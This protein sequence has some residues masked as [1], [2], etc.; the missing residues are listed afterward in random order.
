MREAALDEVRRMIREDEPPRPSQRLSTLEAQAR[1]TVSARRGLDERRL[2]RLLRGDLDWVAMKCLEKNRNRRYEGAGA[3][4][5]DVERH[6][7]DEPVEAR[8]PTAWYR[9]RK[10]ARRNRARLLAAAVALFVVLPAV[11]GSVGWALGDRAERRKNAERRVD[12]GLA[13]VEQ[14]YGRGRWPSAREVAGGLEPLL[15]GG[16]SPDRAERLRAWRADLD[17]VDRLAEIRL[18]QA[19]TLG[20]LAWADGEYAL[21]FREYG[22]DVETLDP[23]RA[24]ERIRT[25]L[26]RVELTAAL[27]DWARLRRDGRRSDGKEWWKRLVAI[28][29]AADPDPTRARVRDALLSGNLAALQELAGSPGVTDLPA[30]TLIN[31]GETLRQMG[32]VDAASALLRRAHVRYPGDFWLN[33]LL[34]VVCSQLKPPQ[35]AEALRFATAAAAINPSSPAAC[36]NIGVMLHRLGLNAEA[37]AWDREAIRLRPD[38]AD[39]HGTLGDALRDLGKPDEAMASYREAIRLRPEFAM[40]HNGLGNTLLRLGKVD[41]AVASYR[42]SIRLEPNEAAGHLNLGVILHDRLGRPAEAAECFRQAIR[43]KPDDADAHYDLGNALL[44]LGKPGEAEPSYREAIRLRPDWAQAHNGLGN[45]LL[46]LGKVDDAVASYRESIRLKSDLALP[47]FNLG[48]VLHDRL[49]RPAEAAEC[50]RQA[51][52]LKP[53]WA[54]AHCNLGLTLERMGKPA[55]AEASYREAIRLKPDLI[56]AH[57]N[58]G[59]ILCDR[60][61]DFDGAIAAF[62]EALRHMPDSAMTQANL[63]VALQKKG[64]WAEAI[65]SYQPPTATW[66]GPWPPVPSPGSATPPGPP[67]WRRR[68]SRWRRTRAGSAT[69]SGWR[70]TAAATGRG[71]SRPSASRWNCKRAA[72]ATTSSSWR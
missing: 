16:I 62:R 27:D 1:S 15:A 57:V 48:A 60:K 17:M 65:A 58:L 2:V 40:A 54:D 72:T 28:A 22:I 21:A 23:A 42:E 7:A 5:A 68:L 50:F 70:C 45:T 69:P 10:L 25:R 29:R 8:P 19:A 53:D 20:G 47:H 49:G 39:A 32:D 41:D 31:L 13:E 59:A 33:N 4:A 67:R 63:G 9:V 36:N 3:L 14:L 55:E 37:V 56:M 44:T 52:R 61:G 18:R 24:T 71:R 64:R 34:C 12:E 11:A 51:I 6:L 43:L 35:Y 38:Y 66:P 30:T 46:R 26:V